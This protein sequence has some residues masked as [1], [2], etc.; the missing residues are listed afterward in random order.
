MSPQSVSLLRSEQ[1][2]GA[3]VVR[4]RVLPNSFRVSPSS[5]SGTCCGSFTPG[6]DIPESRDMAGRSQPSE[7]LRG[8][9]GCPVLA[10][11]SAQAGPSTAVLLRLA[12]GHPVGRAAAISLTRPRMG[13]DS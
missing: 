7:A 2:L 5:S 3:I 4:P 13:N 12:L 9:P 11:E 6:R 10:S 8:V 1:S